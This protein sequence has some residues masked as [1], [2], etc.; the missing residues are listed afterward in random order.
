MKQKLKYPLC[1][2]RNRPEKQG[3][4]ALPLGQCAGGVNFKA[5]KPIREIRGMKMVC[6]SHAPRFEKDCEAAMWSVKSIK[7]LI[8]ILMDSSCY[9]DLDLKER[10]RLIKYLLGSHP[11]LDSRP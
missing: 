10:H 8:R 7:E 5:G 11:A 9:F 4:E 1:H 3:R 2:Y 6:G